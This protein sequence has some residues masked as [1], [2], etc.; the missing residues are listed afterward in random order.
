MILEKTTLVLLGATHERN[1][2]PC[3]NEKICDEMTPHD[4][5]RVV[6]KYVQQNI[7][8]SKKHNL[9]TSHLVEGHRKLIEAMI[10]LDP[11]Q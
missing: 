11:E 4:V 2:L 10:H 7:D 6:A 3:P 9:T 1:Q 8:E 5:L